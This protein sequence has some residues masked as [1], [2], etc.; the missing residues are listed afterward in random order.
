MQGV[1]DKIWWKAKEPK[2]SGKIHSC[3]GFGS[4]HSDKNDFMTSKGWKSSISDTDI[5][6]PSWS[7]EIGATLHNHVQVKSRNFDLGNTMIAIT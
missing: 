4:W 6:Q 2:G 1:A 3:F 5:W 7:L